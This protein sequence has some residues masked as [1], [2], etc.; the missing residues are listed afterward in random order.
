MFVQKRFIVGELA[1]DR[2][3]HGF[4]AAVAVDDI[5]GGEGVVGVDEEVLDS[6]SA[7]VANVLSGEE[8][9]EERSTGAGAAAAG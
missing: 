6:Y 9:G 5:S 2:T 4:E 3:A 8:G 7:A 1:T